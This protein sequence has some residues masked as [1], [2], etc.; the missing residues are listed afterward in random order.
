MT[1]LPTPSRASA[2]RPCLTTHA[3]PARLNSPRTVPTAPGS[4][5]LSCP[6]QAIPT[7]PP[8]TNPIPV[9]LSPAPAD[10]PARDYP[11]LIVPFRST[12]RPAA[13]HPVPAPSDYPARPSVR[14]SQ[15]PRRPMPTLRPSAPTQP[16]FQP[17]SSRLT[18]ALPDC[19]SQRLARPTPRRL[20][21]AWL[22]HTALSDFPS[23]GCTARH[24]LV[25]RPDSPRPSSTPSDYPGPAR[26]C[27]SPELPDE[28]LQISPSPLDP[29]RLPSPWSLIPTPQP[30]A[31]CANQLAHERH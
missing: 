8:C 2:V 1:S 23:P 25:R 12:T 11:A 26:L 6:S 14:P 9:R 24:G 4:P 7:T 17:P 16:T 20:P 5:A 3:C 18:P 13:C 30:G 31:A 22:P 21:S 29:P 28:P 19:P 27:P 10:S 15:P